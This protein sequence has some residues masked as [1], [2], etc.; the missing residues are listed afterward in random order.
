[1]ELLIS[2][3]D[4]AVTDE[5][6][7]LHAV[8]TPE[9]HWESTRTN[10]SLGLIPG[11]PQVY[12]GG[13]PMDLKTQYELVTQFQTGNKR[14]IGTLLKGYDAYI[15]QQ[16]FRFISSGHPDFEDCLQQGRMGFMAACR[17]FDTSRGLTLTTYGT[18]YIRSYIRRFLIDSG[19][20]VR[21]PIQQYTTRWAQDHNTSRRSVRKREVY[22]FCELSD[23]LY[24]EA[25]IPFEDV[26][27]DDKP[28]AEDTLREIELEYLTQKVAASAIRGQ[29]GRARD[30]I[31]RRFN[32]N[33]QNLVEIAHLYKLS[34]ERIRQIEAGALST[35]RA[36]LDTD[37]PGHSY[38]DW[39]IT[40]R[41]SEN[42]ST[43][44]EPVALGARDTPCPCGATLYYSTDPSIYHQCKACRKKAKQHGRTKT[45]ARTRT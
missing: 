25:L 17:R 15:H 2:F 34:R 42:P 8:S 13:D 22:L 41:R 1:M 28:L 16:T 45:S 32:D 27:V 36:N 23:I 12:I 20:V 44:S 3:A 7:G 30:V 6:R 5:S 11:S 14:A 43:T 18:H 29:N 39:V 24:E 21:F 35:M 19:A 33:P 26:L 31:R 9:K 40:R 37:R 38:E 4:L 10:F